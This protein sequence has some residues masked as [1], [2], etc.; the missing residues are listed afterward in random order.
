MLSMIDKLWKQ[1]RCST[2]EDWIREIHAMKFPSLYVICRKMDATG[3]NCVKQVKPT[4]QRQMPYM[5]P[6][7]G[8]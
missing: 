1:F 2:S 6:I 7:P 8:S 3:T 5:L 4:A